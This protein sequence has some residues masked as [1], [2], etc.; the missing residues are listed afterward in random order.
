M[1]GP[2]VNLSLPDWVKPFLEKNNS[3]FPSI[4]ERMDFVVTLSRQNVKHATGGP[5]GAAVF[6]PD[7]RL[8]APG[9]NMVLSANCSVL[10]AETVAL[11]LAQKALGRYDI[12]DN[13]KSSYDLVAS[14]QPCVMCFGAVIWS[15]IRRLICGARGE[16]ARHIGFDEG[17]R[18]PNWVAELNCRGIDVLR[19]VRREE[20]SRVLR[21]YVT[22]GG[23]IYNPGQPCGQD[24]V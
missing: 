24:G 23:P 22:A 11:I 16:D 17:P 1:H 18:L 19:D 15:G 7:G 6:N 4:E 9:V 21:E 3:S 2:T 10:H 12:G 5:F 13:G 8:I 14:T 20:A